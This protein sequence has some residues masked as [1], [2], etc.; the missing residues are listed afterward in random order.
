MLAR[1]TANYSVFGLVDFGMQGACV[2]SE[3]FVTL[4]FV[5]LLHLV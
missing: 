5:F 1:L 3:L 4:G 2:C